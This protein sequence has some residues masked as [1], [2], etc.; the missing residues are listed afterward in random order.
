MLHYET[1]DSHKH[2]FCKQLIVHCAKLVIFFVLQKIY[3]RCISSSG[4]SRFS[5]DIKL[6]FLQGGNFGFF[7]DIMGYDL[8]KVD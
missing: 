8:E 3:C 4:N 6:L 5:K 1:F 7:T 2:K